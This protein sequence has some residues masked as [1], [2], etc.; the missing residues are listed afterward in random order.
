MIVSEYVRTRCTTAVQSL[1]LYVWSRPNTWTT[2]VT[3]ESRNDAIQYMKYCT[4]VYPLLT[5]HQF[6]GCA[7]QKMTLAII[8][9]LYIVNDPLLMRHVLAMQVMLVHMMQCELI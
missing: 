1:T 4:M 3:K 2:R 8:G 9:T 7:Y 6:R 5:L